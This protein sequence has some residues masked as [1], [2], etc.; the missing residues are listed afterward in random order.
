MEVVMQRNAPEADVQNIYQK[1]KDLLVK[2][3]ARALQAVN[4][5]MVVC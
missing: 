1:V 3:R 5:E 2:A 4:T